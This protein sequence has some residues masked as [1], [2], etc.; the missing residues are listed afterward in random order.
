[1]S[2]Q[3][4]DECVKSFQ[5]LK[6]LLMLAFILTL[7]DEAVDFIVYCDACRVKLGGVICKKCH[8]EIF[9]DYKSLQYIFIQ[10]DLNLRQRKWIELLKN[11]DITILYHLGKAN[12]VADALSRKT[13]S[14]GSLAVIS[15]EDRPLARYV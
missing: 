13:S 9:M 11:Y 4:S 12:V 14:T 15:V 2:F 7:P 8:C 6:V 1:M 10:R 5:N 3:W